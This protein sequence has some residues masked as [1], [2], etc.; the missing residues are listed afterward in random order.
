M[1]ILG[2][3]LSC[4]F[5]LGIAFAYAYGRTLR[6]VLRGIPFQDGVRHLNKAVCVC[7]RLFFLY[8]P[9]YIR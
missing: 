3:A 5:Q 2:V 9:V 4:N 6:G 1:A 7:G 8:P